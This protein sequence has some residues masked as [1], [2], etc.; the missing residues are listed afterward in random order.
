[1][2]GQI[3][4]AVIA[5]AVSIAL[6]G[7]GTIIGA[8]IN[9]AIGSVVSQAVG[10]ATGIQE[11]FSFKAVALAAIGAGV[12]VGVGDVLGK[13]AML[14]SKFVGDVVR[15][16]VSSAVTQGVGVATG[17]QDKFSWAGVAAAGI[18]AGVGGAVGRG[19]ESKS[20]LFGMRASQGSFGYTLATATAGGIANAAMRSAINGESFGANLIAAIPD[21]V[22]G[23]L[24]GAVRGGGD[25]D[26]R[27]LTDVLNSGVI[28]A[29]D[30]ER[31]GSLAKKYGVD[32]IFT[33]M[34]SGGDGND[35]KFGFETTTA[36]QRKGAEKAK[37]D[38]LA[39]GKGA[40]ASEA[41]YY[42]VARLIYLKE[43]VQLA[44][45][46]TRN[47][48]FRKFERVFNL[49]LLA[50]DA[51][52]ST[53]ISELLPR[54][55][56]VY[57]S[58]DV[59]GFSANSSN[60][61]FARLYRGGNTIYLVNRGTDDTGAGPLGRTSDGRT[62][63]TNLAGGLSGQ[64]ELAADNAVALVAH[65][66]RGKLG[67]HFVGHSLGGSL[68][69]LQAV[70]TGQR[71]TT[72]NSTN[73]EVSTVERYIN[74]GNLKYRTIYAPRGGGSRRVLIV[75][76]QAKQL[77]SRTNE[78]IDYYYV[79][80]DIARWQKGAGATQ[81]GSP[82]KLSHDRFPVGLAKTVRG[83]G[84]AAD[85]QRP[86]VVYQ[87]HLPTAHSMNSIIYSLFSRVDAN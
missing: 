64:H 36:L 12:G 63:A 2:F 17:L 70:V 40:E 81:V 45:A 47:A 35:G 58:G 37:A 59:G 69:S 83:K 73:L 38:Y 20:G 31:L 50:K 41:A 55:F 32:S 25:G 75:S 56:S 13:G 8:A 72:F 26:A 44:G 22:G 34:L 10:V 14:G 53:S 68:A 21:I 51:Y 54:G 85:T 15:G 24:G 7:G 3:L 18:G 71:A 19:L 80:G 65:A 49:A 76:E 86:K 5:V 4:L 39:R 82:T 43:Q 87:H 52:F 77:Y 11:K 60:G 46:G 28:P 16:A 30:A 42:D 61:Y 23:A 84:A 9:G 78:L 66:R 1:V 57:S 67:V 48:S 79:D 29:E 74:R 6:P 27:E 33:A 62:N